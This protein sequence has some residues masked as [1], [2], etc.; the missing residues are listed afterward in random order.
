MA[1]DT[2]AISLEEINALARQYLGTGKPLRVQLLP[3][4]VK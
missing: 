3:E 2:E 1:K 4:K